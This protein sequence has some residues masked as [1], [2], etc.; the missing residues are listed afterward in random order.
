MTGAGAPESRSDIRTCS[1]PFSRRMKLSAL[2]KRQNST[3]NSGIGVRGFSSRKTG[4]QSSSGAPKNSELWIP[5]DIA[6]LAYRTP[7][8]CISA[9]RMGYSGILQGQTIAQGEN[10]GARLLYATQRAHK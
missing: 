2:A 6:F 9:A 10:H 7:I 4:A 1:R 5:W 8:S 3:L